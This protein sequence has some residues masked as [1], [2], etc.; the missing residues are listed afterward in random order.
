MDRRRKPKLSLDYKTNMPKDH[1]CEVQFLKIFR[2][3]KL[4]RLQSPNKQHAFLQ[5]NRKCPLFNII[6]E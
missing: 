2:Y 1:V 3:T 6:Y 4:R 5:L